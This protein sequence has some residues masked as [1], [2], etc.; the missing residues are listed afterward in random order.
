MTTFRFRRGPLAA[1]ALLVSALAVGGVA[2]PSEAAPKG[3]T[4]LQILSFN[5]YHGHLQPPAGSDGTLVTATGTTT[6]SN[7]GTTISRMAAAVEMS[8]HRA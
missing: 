5:D 3:T 7:P 6:A 2:L 8:T 4:D 1:A